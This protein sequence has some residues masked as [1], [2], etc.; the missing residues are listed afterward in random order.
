MIFF[1]TTKVGLLGR[2]ANLY[3]HHVSVHNRNI[4]VVYLSTFS[5]CSRHHVLC[6]Q[7]I[8]TFGVLQVGGAVGTLFNLIVVNICWGYVTCY[9]YLCLFWITPRIGSTLEKLMSE[10]FR[11]IIVV[12]MYT[13]LMHEL[14]LK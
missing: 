10:V 8:V 7:L 14:W 4:H 11:S 12:M 13:V 3:L 5:V 2:F 6:C 9:I 1:F